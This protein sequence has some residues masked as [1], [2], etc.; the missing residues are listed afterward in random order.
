MPGNVIAN[1]INRLMKYL[2]ASPQSSLEGVAE[3][4]VDLVA[5][6]PRPAVEREGRVEPQQAERRRR[7]QA[8]AERS[9]EIEARVPRP[10]PH[11]ASVEKGEAG[12]RE[13]QREAQLLVDHEQRL[14]PRRPRDVEAERLPRPQGLLPV[15]AHRERAAG[16]EQLVADDLLARERVRDAQPHRLRPGPRPAAQPQ[17][18]ERRHLAEQAGVLKVAAKEA[19]A[20]R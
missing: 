5:A 9:G 2:T 16:E 19:A 15:A 12:E 8:E 1:R 17:G 6:V 10:G 20:S 4:G 3:A 13:R 11:L 7:P 14:A 18:T